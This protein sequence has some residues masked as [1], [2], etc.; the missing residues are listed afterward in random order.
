MIQLRNDSEPNGKS[1]LAKLSRRR[2]GR[3]EADQEHRSR[4]HDV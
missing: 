1:E 4:E 2:L 3:G